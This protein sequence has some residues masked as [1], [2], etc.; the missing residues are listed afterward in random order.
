MSVYSIFGSYLCDEYTISTGPYKNHHLSAD[1][2]ANYMNS[3]IN[4][5]IAKFKG[6]PT[7]EH[8]SLLFAT[9]IDPH[10]KTEPAKEFFRIKKNMIRIIHQ[11]AVS[12]GEQMDKSATPIYRFQLLLII[13]AYALFGTAEVDK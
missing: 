7:I 6:S 8:K 13:T 1:S 10:S 9:C 3:I 4:S 12:E 5:S 2:A 11:R